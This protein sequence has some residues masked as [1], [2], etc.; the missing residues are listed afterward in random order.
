MGFSILIQDTRDTEVTKHQFSMF[1]ITEEEVAWLDILMQDAALM[2]VGQRS[3]SLQS[4][5]AE[6]I[7]I[8]IKTILL[9]RASLEEL[10]QFIISVFAINISLA[11]VKHLD[12][13]L[14]V[15][16]INSLKNFFVNVKIRIIDLQYV[17]LSIVLNQKYLGLTSI[18][19]QRLEILILIAFQQEE[20]IIYIIIL[21]RKSVRSGRASHH[22]RRPYRS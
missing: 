1:R 9:H 10:H 19:T 8:S 11:K 17:L 18:F 7:H 3:R 21:R 2:T 22:S 15:E 16:V 6:L 5:S 13:H 14:K 12:N 4:N 20:L